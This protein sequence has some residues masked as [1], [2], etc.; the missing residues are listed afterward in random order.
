MSFDLTEYAAARR[1][2]VRNLHDG[3]PVP[4]FRVRVTKRGTAKGYT[5]ADDRDDAV[6]GQYGYVAD[7][8]DGRLE[9]FLRRTNGKAA[10]VRALAAAGAIVAQ[11]GDGEAAGSAPV[12]T[13]AVLIELIRPYTRKDPAI[14]RARA[15]RLNA[16]TST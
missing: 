8:G 1:Y 2:R 14:G 13:I 6:I 7:G 16:G 15:A 9:W 5:G 4:P 11:D 3:R 12:S 10:A